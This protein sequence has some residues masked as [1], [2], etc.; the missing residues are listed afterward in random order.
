M[1]SS[2]RII[3]YIPSSVKWS[4]NV[5][6]KWIT[7]LGTM[8]LWYPQTKLLYFANII[9]S[10]AVVYMYT[11]HFVP[12]S[13]QLVLAHS[14]LWRICPI[15]QDL[16]YDHSWNVLWSLVLSYDQS[17]YVLWSLVLSYDHSW[18]VLWSQGI[19]LNIFMISNGIQ[20][21]IQQNIFFQFP[22][23]EQQDLVYLPNIIPTVLL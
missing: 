2:T 4:S 19:W 22:K 12:S 3:P 13:L 15:I 1:I 5:S 14:V 11:F 23:L 7:I 17:I 21:N 16:S 20:S 10:I 9:R 18:Y 8:T 6:N